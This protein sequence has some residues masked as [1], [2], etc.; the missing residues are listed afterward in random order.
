[1][2][3]PLNINLIIPFK[4]N[5]AGRLNLYRK[6]IEAFKEMLGQRVEELKEELV[7]LFGENFELTLAARSDGNSRKYYW[8]FKSSKRDRKYNR[9]HA[10]SIVEYLRVFD[11]ER[12]LRL[13]ETEEE[14]I[15]INAN[16]KLIKGMLDSIDQA[17]DEKAEL[18][19][20][21]I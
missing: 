17:V 8:R 10:D 11:D 6:E 13:K 20:A 2:S 16:L 5:K 14:L 19:S 4:D 21:I 7:S 1:M 9:L 12:K 15:Y 3:V 18:R